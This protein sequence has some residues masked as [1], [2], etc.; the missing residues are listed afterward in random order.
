VLKT[1]L[2]LFL[3]ALASSSCV[4]SENSNSQDADTYSEIGGSPGFSSVRSI[5]RQ[6]CANCH[7]YHTFTEEQ[8]VTAGALKKGDPANSSIYYRLVGSTQGGGPKNMPTGGTLTFSDLQ[9]IETWI[10]NAN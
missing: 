8:L 5:L 4:Q 10:E 3:I 6:N 1:L 2:P 9:L 7:S